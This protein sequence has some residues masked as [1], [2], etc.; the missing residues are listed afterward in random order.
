MQSAAFWG[1]PNCGIQKIF[2]I[3]LYVHNTVAF[4]KIPQSQCLIQNQDNIRLQTVIDV[5]SAEISV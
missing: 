4:L 1:I 5:L 3:G 2:L